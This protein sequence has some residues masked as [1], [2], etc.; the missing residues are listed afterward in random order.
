[1]LKQVVEAKRMMVIVIQT[2]TKQYE[3]NTKWKIH[4]QVVGINPIYNINEPER[5]DGGYLIHCE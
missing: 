3:K 5:I 2:K 4:P 1:M